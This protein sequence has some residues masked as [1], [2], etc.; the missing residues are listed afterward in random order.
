MLADDVAIYIYYS[1]NPY[2]NWQPTSKLYA[3]KNLRTVYIKS[4]Y[5]LW[6]SAELNGN[7]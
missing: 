4:I 2:K 7:K 5:V 1:M 3:Y 6:N